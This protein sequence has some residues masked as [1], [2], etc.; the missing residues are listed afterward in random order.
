MLTNGRFCP[1]LTAMDNWDEGSQEAVPRKRQRRERGEGRFYFTLD[2]LVAVLG[3]SRRTLRRWRKQGK[4]NPRD[5][6][7]VAKLL[8]T[9]Q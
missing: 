9:R 2:D 4:F 8:R 7:S 1:S 5:F 3:R 6:A